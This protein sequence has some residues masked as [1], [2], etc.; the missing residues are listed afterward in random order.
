VGA[1][2]SIIIPNWNG[3]EVI[4]VCLESIIQHTTGT[5]FEVV[6]I[7]NGSTDGSR[8]RILGFAEADVRIRTIFN[9]ENLLFARAC[10]QGYDSCASRYVLVANN[11]I[12]LRDDA[13]SSLV[14]YTDEHPSAGVVTPRFI[15]RDG[16]PQ[17][18][19]RRLPNVFHILAH[20]HP[21]GRAIDRIALNRRFQNA[22][23]Y[24][25][26]VFDRIE[27]I[28][29]AGASFS[30]FRRDVLERIGGLFDERFPLLFND[31]DLS[32]RIRD[33]G[34]SSHVVPSIEVVHLEG[35]SSR[36]F[37]QEKYLHLQFQGM[38]RYFQKHHAMQYPLLCLA[39]PLRWM[40]MQKQVSEVATTN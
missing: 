14:Q 22:Y 7:D 12:L 11:D 32:H 10:N 13:V 26:R 25:D 8:D 19:V 9:N 4:G 27:E 1:T 40:K 3:E 29:Q 24:R 37:D 20:Y 39:W 2:V 15:D 5:S 35:V 34:F 16:R 36:K 28:E 30:L 18:F 38:F 33:A 17:E 21:L 23:F 31:V 6:V